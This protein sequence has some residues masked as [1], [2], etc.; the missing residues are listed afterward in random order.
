MRLTIRAATIAAAA[1]TL[2]ATVFAGPSLAWEIEA[3][4]VISTTTTHAAAGLNGSAVAVNAVNVPVQLDSSMDF[5]TPVA[6]HAVATL[7]DEPVVEEGAKPEPKSRS[8]H[9]LVRDFSSTDV[10]DEEQRCLAG[11][12]YFES[13]GEPLQG[14]LAVAE[15]IINRAESGRFADTLCGVVKQRG[16]FSFI[17]GGKFPAIATN[18]DNWRKAVAIAKIAQQDLSE[19]SV[20]N[21][22][23]F[24][25]R[26]VSPGWKKLKRVATLGNHVFYR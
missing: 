24:H 17:R 21:A 1:A 11:A 7:K 23:F 14:Q 10:A 8:L 12:V 5:S 2:T 22:L 16:Q 15:V 3:V 13:K 4:P 18:S 25:A 26:R 9:D 6:T 19:S 20:S